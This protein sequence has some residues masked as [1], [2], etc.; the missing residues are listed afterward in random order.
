[1][2][3]S[4]A[5]RACDAAECFPHIITSTNDRSFV[6]ILQYY[7]TTIFYFCYAVGRAS[8]SHLCI[9]PAVKHDRYAP[10]K[11]TKHNITILQYYNIA[12]MS[13]RRLRHIIDRGAHANPVPCTNTRP[14]IKTSQHLLQAEFTDASDKYYIYS[15][16]CILHISRIYDIYD[17]RGLRGYG[18]SDRLTGW[19][20]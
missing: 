17:T 13:F 3:R 4:Y 15:I 1:M 6:T 8:L 5:A 10:T 19:H 2:T 7:N 9:D 14:T 20:L 16:Y 12:S 18:S 11:E